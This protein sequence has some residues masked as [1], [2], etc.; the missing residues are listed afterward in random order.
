MSIGNFVNFI[1][2]HAILA[3]N[4]LKRS[5]TNLDLKYAGLRTVLPHSWLRSMMIGIFEIRLKVSTVAEAKPGKRF[6]TC[7]SQSS[8]AIFKRPSIARIETVT[9]SASAC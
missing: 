8:K 6:T 4:G 7:S 9:K 3:M 5:V 2:K 1:S